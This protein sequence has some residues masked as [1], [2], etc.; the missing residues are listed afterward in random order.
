[1][2]SQIAVVAFIISQVVNSS[3][4]AVTQDQLTQSAGL[5]A[6]DAAL[7]VLSQFNGIE[8]MLESQQPNI[9]GVNQK[10]EMVSSGIEGNVTH[11]DYTCV[12]QLSGGSVLSDKTP[13]AYNDAALISAD[14]EM[15]YDV[16][17]IFVGQKTQMP[18]FS[19]HF[20]DANVDLAQTQW[21]PY[22]VYDYTVDI[23][24]D[25]TTGGALSTST[26]NP[27]NIRI[28][29][30]HVGSF[31]LQNSASGFVTQYSVDTRAIESCLN[32]M[33]LN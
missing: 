20:F 29:P 30:A 18:S 19:F 33:V 8:G 26:S 3:A 24:F 16:P 21:L 27:K 14:P 17:F 2:K 5:C 7:K 1:M 11:K 23:T 22:V 25:T 32:G 9:Y 12:L 4:Q 13:V 28:K 15:G 31:Y 10:C 6:S